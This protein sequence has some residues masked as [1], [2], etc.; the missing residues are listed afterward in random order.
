MFGGA[1]EKRRERTLRSFKSEKEAGGRECVLL[2]SGPSL[3]RFSRALGK[4]TRTGKKKK[5]SSE[6]VGQCIATLFAG[7]SRD[8][9]RFLRAKGRRKKGWLTRMINLG[10][11]S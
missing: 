11:T 10:G 4:G 9:E 8:R 6:K 5:E 3:R 7:A 2:G 1:G